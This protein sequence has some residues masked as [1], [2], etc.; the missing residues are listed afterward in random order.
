MIIILLTKALN[1]GNVW[2]IILNLSTKLKCSDKQTGRTFRF[3]RKIKYILYLQASSSKPDSVRT[4][5]SSKWL[6]SV[7]FMSSLSSIPLRQGCSVHSL[8]CST[9]A[10]ILKLWSFNSTGL[11]LMA[12]LAVW[13][14]VLCDYSRRF[15]QAIS[16]NN[17]SGL[18]WQSRMYQWEK[19]VNNALNCHI[20]YIKVLVWLQTQC[21]VRL[22][23]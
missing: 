8:L 9:A 5:S 2:S 12:P 18:I 22:T 13:A 16:Q 17:V 19:M 11:F 21:I 15:S 6:S 14:R 4:L 23:G 20:M 3:A 10:K 1:T 7:S